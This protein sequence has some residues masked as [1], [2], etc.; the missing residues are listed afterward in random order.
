M[1]SRHCDNCNYDLRTGEQVECEFIRMP[2]RKFTIIFRIDYEN[3]TIPDLC[4]L[5]TCSL[6]KEAFSQYTT[7]VNI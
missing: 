2:I 4:E 1:I 7:E 6:L 3:S 5:C